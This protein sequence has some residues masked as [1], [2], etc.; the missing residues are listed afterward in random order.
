MGLETTTYIAGLTPAWPLAGDPKNQ[1]DDHLRLLKSV[2]QA[3]FPSASKP[4]YFPA[5]E[6]ISGTQVLDATDMNNTQFVDTSGGNVAVTLPSGF[7]TTEKG[8][9]V[10]VVK[11]TSDTNAVIV[12]PAS[13]TIS[14]QVGAVATVRVG[15]L[16]EPATF[17]W[18]G[19]T[20]VCYKPG[21]AIGS[22]YEF[23][24]AL[25]AGYLEL[26]GT[27]YSNTAF[28]ELFAYL[29][30]TTLKDKGGRVSA[31]RE[32]T[33][34]RLTATHFG[35]DSTVPG[36]TGGLESNTLTTPQLPSH[37][38]SNSLNDPGHTH[39]ETGSEVGGASNYISKPNNGSSGVVG[40]SVNS[41]VANTTG[42][43]ITNAAAGGGGAHNNT[44]PTIIVRKCIRAC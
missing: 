3:T 7:G 38:H 12:S 29:A 32:A 20:W 39:I 8:W 37:T 42:I 36:G 34:S 44:Q 23:D 22:T 18:T 9:R 6:A 1:G 43:T 16:C 31:G 5:A 26:N 24:N 15:V 30:S 41:T 21:A 28:A 10:D 40:N 4:F 25:P 17:V 35:G 14:T 13:G 33:A 27:T 19:S 2:L 11:T